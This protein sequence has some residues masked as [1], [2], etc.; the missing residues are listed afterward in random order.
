MIHDNQTNLE[1][2]QKSTVTTSESL[3][4]VINDT[5]DRKISLATERPQSYVAMRLFFL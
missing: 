4:A 1:R 2:T 5:T 3:S